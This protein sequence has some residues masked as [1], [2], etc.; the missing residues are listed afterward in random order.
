MTIRSLPDTI[1]MK[2]SSS[3]PNL[4]KSY[5]LCSKDIPSLLW[6]CFL[7][8]CIPPDMKACFHRLPTTLPSSASQPWTQARICF[9]PCPSSHRI[10]YS[11]S[12]RGNMPLSEDET[13]GIERDC[14]NFLIRISTP[15][16]VRRVH[17][18]CKETNKAGLS[19]VRS[20]R[21]CCKCS[22]VRALK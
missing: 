7:Y 3:C 9:P 4:Q 1:N 20:S 16:I 12:L 11:C 19:S 6:P 21:Y 5:H 13:L 22:L 17:G 8:L 2:C 15:L 10:H 14:P 18:E